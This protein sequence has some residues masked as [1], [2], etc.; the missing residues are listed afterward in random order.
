MAHSGEPWYL[1]IVRM[2]GIPFAR[3]DKS[4]R[5][6]VTVSVVGM[7]HSHSTDLG[8]DGQNP[9][10]KL[11]LVLYDVDRH[12][13]LDIK[14][15]HHARTKK[16]GRKPHLIGSA[17]VTLCELSRMQKH[18]EADVG[19]SLRCPPP[20]K[21]NPSIKARQ[22]NSATLIAR[23]RPPPLSP[24]LTSE[25]TLVAYEDD[26]VC[27][28]EGFEEELLSDASRN[29]TPAPCTDKSPV[30]I[31]DILPDTSASG[32]KKRRKRTK[33]KPYSL[34]SDDEASC[35][36]SSE[37][38]RPATP[39]PHQ[40]QYYSYYAE[41]GLE[42][43]Y[44]AEMTFGD[45]L[46]SYCPA[47][48]PQHIGESPEEQRPLSLIKLMVDMFAPF[49]E[50]SGPG[51][52]FASVLGR[53]TTEWYAVG[54]CLLAMA[55]LNAAVFGYSTPTLIDIDSIALKARSAQDVY[56]TYFFFCL[57][58]RFPTLCLL[59]AVCALLAFLLAVAW[60][61]WSVAV[62]VMCCAAGVLLTLQ[63]LVYGAHRTV[64]FFVWLVWRAGRAC[65]GLFR[66]TPPAGSNQ[67]LPGQTAAQVTPPG[68][69]RQT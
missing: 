21:R 17:Y 6:R 31:P 40:E 46:D 9:N 62:L 22:A 59:V 55:A 18:S 16:K 32:L 26:S 23:L 68:V 63:Y 7:A 33:L 51:C 64:N 60:G 15:W 34:D 50:M 27:D 52:D 39:P 3:Q 14:V 36:S 5:P 65:D 11:P 12:S 56:G 25:T 49:R 53:L 38:S 44:Q 67:A 10:L 20:Q 47:I 35:Y 13:K 66:A 19:I 41:T 57:T 30:D 2:Q 69:T 48:L 1:T 4:W 24:S 43:E 54:G 28:E 61:A 58:C 37:S 29:T 45:D 8:C 42:T